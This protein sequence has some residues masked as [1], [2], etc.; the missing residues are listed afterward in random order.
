MGKGSKLGAVGV[1]KANQPLETTFS[2]LEMLQRS[3]IARQLSVQVIQNSMCNALSVFLDV[4]A[5]LEEPFVNHS[6]TGGFMVSQ[7]ASF[8]PS[9]WP[10]SHIC[11]SSR[12]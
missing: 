1:S 7:T 9:L 4:L 3:K 8:V 6:L 12:D 2:V 10:D 11:N 5:S